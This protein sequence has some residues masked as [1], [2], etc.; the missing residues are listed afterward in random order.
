MLSTPP[1]EM[2]YV[3]TIGDAAHWNIQLAGL[4]KISDPTPSN[5]A[6]ACDK[7]SF[8]MSPEDGVA[9]TNYA[10]EKKQ[11]SGGGILEHKIWDISDRTA[12]SFKSYKIS[13][14]PERQIQFATDDGTELGDIGCKG[15][16][17]FDKGELA[18]EVTTSNGW[19]LSVPNFF[20]YPSGMSFKQIKA[21][22]QGLDDVGPNLRL[23]RKAETPKQT[24]CFVFRGN[25]KVDEEPCQKTSQSTLN[26]GLET[27]TI[28]SYQ[29]PSGG[30]T[31]LEK[32]RGKTLI[33][34]S[35]T[36][37]LR[38]RKKPKPIAENWKISCLKNTKTGNAFCFKD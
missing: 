15:Y 36:E 17:E 34:G 26:F 13:S 12:D 38:G 33:N 8:Q 20:I 28:D 18:A 30:K 23:A 32:Q 37:L 9:A 4:P 2:Y 29:W 19:F 14:G 10:L 22:A 35:N 21:S 27:Y 24:T 5:I 31:V 3:E 1:N 25:T 6:A 11:N 7:L 16:Y